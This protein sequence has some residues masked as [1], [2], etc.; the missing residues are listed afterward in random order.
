ML[1]TLDD[2]SFGYSG[3]SVLSGIT[4][5]IER[6]DFVG[7]IGPNGSGK[8]TLLK[9]LLGIVKPLSGSFTILGESGHNII[10]VRSSLGY[11]PQRNNVD[12]KFPATVNDVV[13][14]GTYG[15]LGLARRP[16]RLERQKVKEA[17]ER[18]GLSEYGT[19]HISQL[20]GGQLQRVLI[21]RALVSD[22]AILLLDE[23]TSA[24]D[25]T[26]EQSILSFLE[27]INKEIG[28]TI[29]MVT[30]NVNEIVHMANKI[31]VLNGRLEAFGHPSEVLNAEMVARV[32]G[33]Y[34]QACAH[35]SSPVLIVGDRS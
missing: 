34:I 28:I 17:L 4:I 8:S 11:V 12:T 13:L 30:H 7:I 26:A 2:V 23:P 14:M 20:S 21:A 6:G 5:A 15:K 24:V 32:F 25:V 35:G 19:R 18:V 3:R 27:S 31:A 33:G 1:I 10:K 22:P 29:V 16:G 9:G